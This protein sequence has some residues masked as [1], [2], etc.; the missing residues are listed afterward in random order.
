MPTEIIAELSTSHGG[1]R[2]WQEKLI[3]S[4]AG[5]GADYVKF[6]SGQVAHL[7]KDDPQY[8]W[9]KQAEL[10]DRDHPRLIASC[11]KAGVTFLTTVFHEDRVPFLAGLGM[12]AIKVGS[13]E[14]MREPLLRAVAAH[15][16]RV[17]LSTGLLTRDE[18]ELA[19]ALLQGREVTLLHTVS[20]YPTL[21]VDAN[22]RRIGWL[23]ARTGLP[24]GYSDHT[25][26]C[27]PALVA[28]AWGV[29]V[30]E[31]HYALAGA[32]RNRPWDK[33]EVELK[34]ICDFRDVVQ[35]VTISGSMLKK[36]GAPRPFVGRWDA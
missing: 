15:P 27:D 12:P 36:V 14:A 17:F 11:A 26:G 20:C 4:A 16:W 13:G 25:I 7:S 5:A 3:A 33:H 22:L 23:A 9:M 10:S 35:Q 8:G 21:T 6:Q 32:P 24:V 31:V 34:R 2:A 19:L 30:V 18:L 1:E 29:P 28:I